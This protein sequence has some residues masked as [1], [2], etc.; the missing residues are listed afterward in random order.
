MSIMN[1]QNHVFIREDPSTIAVAVIHIR[2]SQRHEKVG[3]NKMTCV[4][5]VCS[6]DKTQLRE[7]SAQ[8]N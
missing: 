7:V 3:S 1:A 6:A 5:S 8:S 4:L 2:I